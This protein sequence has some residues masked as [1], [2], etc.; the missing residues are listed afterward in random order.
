[1]PE[2]SF[3]NSLDGCLIN[4]VRQMSQTQMSQTQSSYR[5]VPTWLA[6]VVDCNLLQFVHL[7]GKKYITKPNRLIFGFYAVSIHHKW[8]FSVYAHLISFSNVVE[9]KSSVVI[10]QILAI[11]NTKSPESS[12]IDFKNKI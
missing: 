2:F 5:H 4:Q 7:R 1:M 11:A 3:E 10:G 12:N 8:N 9:V 6:V